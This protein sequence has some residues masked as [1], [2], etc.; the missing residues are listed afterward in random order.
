MSSRRAMA[1]AIRSTATLIPRS[2]YGECNWLSD[3]KRKSLAVE[4]SR[5]PRRTRSRARSGE[6]SAS[7][8]SFSGRSGSGWRKFHRIELRLLFFLVGVV[9]QDAIVIVNGVFQALKSLIP[10]CGHF[11]Q[12]DH[13]L[14]WESDLN[15]A[16]FA[17]KLAQPACFFHV[18]FVHIFDLLKTVDEQVDIFL[19]KID[20][21]HGDKLHAGSAGQLDKVL[22]RVGVVLIH[23]PGDCRHFVADVSREATHPMPL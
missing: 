6:T 7:A 18:F 15:E 17:H 13:A 16:H 8:I 20:E 14:A 3:G 9:D 23:A 21:V 22:P 10:V 4:V 11:I 12:E 1:A 19:I 2:R 5:I